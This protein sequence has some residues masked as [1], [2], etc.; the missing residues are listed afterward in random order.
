MQAKL[1]HLDFIQSAISRMAHNSFLLKGWSITLI[2]ALF[3]LSK[4]NIDYKITIIAIVLISM[5]WVLDA[6]YLSREHYFRCLYDEIREK[7]PD[8]IDFSMKTETILTK[9]M[10]LIPNIISETLLFF[11]LM[12]M[13]IALLFG[14]LM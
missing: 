8:K 4:G 12:L 14:F 2:G 3:A 10:L 7:A 9:K 5:F 11:Y 1:K 6:Y 13:F